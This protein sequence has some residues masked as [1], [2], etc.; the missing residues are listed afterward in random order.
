[1]R[2]R[3]LMAGAVLLA[4]AVAAAGWTIVLVARA[5]LED[6]DRLSSVIGA[7]GSLVL[8]ATGLW[9]A[10]RARQDAAGQPAST[11]INQASGHGTVYGV[12]GGT[13]NV[14]DPSVPDDR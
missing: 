4:C 3:R 13:L 11:Q 14:T 7:A 10:L 1:M 8:G 5:G 6:A 12:Q 9:V 2:R